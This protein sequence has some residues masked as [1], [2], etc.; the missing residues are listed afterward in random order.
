MTSAGILVAAAAASRK[1]MPTATMLAIAASIRNAEAG[2]GAVGANRRRPVP[3]GQVD[4]LAAE[5]VATLGHA[6]AR[7]SVG[8]QDDSAWRGTEGQRCDRADHVVHVRDEPAGQAGVGQRL[9]DDSW[10]AVM[11]R[12]LS[13]E[14]VRDHP[15]SRRR[16]GGD[17]GG[18]RIRMTDADQHAGAG[19]LLDRRHATV[20]LRREGDD[21][22][23]AGSSVEQ[24]ADRRLV[25]RDDPRGVVRPA[26]ARGDERTLE[27]HAEYPRTTGGAGAS[28]TWPARSRA[29][30]AVARRAATRPSTG[31]VM[32]V[33]KNA[34]V[35]VSG[36][37]RTTS[38]HPAGSAS[39]S[40]TPK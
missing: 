4:R 24:P 21:S 36:S 34:V 6:R 18:C 25:G 8:D 33:G 40:S 35:P 5:H 23:K 9:A 13:V 30:P 1:P 7:G 15:R 14:Q 32:N 17:L 22:D 12:P 3:A 31:L 10:L 11:Q 27:V 20:D 38:A 37:R 26:P 28:R 16:G 2:E 19:E 29:N 39:P